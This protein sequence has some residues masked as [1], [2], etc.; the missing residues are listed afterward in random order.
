[1]KKCAWCDGEGKNKIVDLKGKQDFIC[2]K[3]LKLSDAEKYRMMQA[4]K[5][6]DQHKNRN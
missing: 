1:M 6:T 5:L 2:D 3:C 4:K